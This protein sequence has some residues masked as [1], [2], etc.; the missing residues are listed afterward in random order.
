MTTIARRIV[1][2]QKARFQD[3]LLHL[4]LDLTYVTDHI[5]IM[6]FPA[7][8]VASLYRN[9]RSDVRRFLDKR[10]DDLYRVYNFCP[11]TEN[12]Y[13]PDEFYGRVSRFP[14]PDHHVP[15][16]SLIPLFVADITEYLES[17][18][19][20][21][22][23]IHCKA[24]K[25]RSGTMTCCY[26]VSLPYLPT[27][28]TSVRNYSKMQRPENQSVAPPPPLAAN[29][30]ST[31][32]ERQPGAVQT[33]TSTRML[34]P[35]STPEPPP[36]SSSSSCM[37]TLQIPRSAAWT[38]AAPIV[39]S[40]AGTLRRRPSL[41]PEQSIIRNDDLNPQAEID[42]I[43]QRLQTIFDLHTERRM[44]PPSKKK[45]SATIGRQRSR[46][47]AAA[48][49]RPSAH[50]TG[51]MNSAAVSTASLRA[52]GAGPAGRSCDAL[53][54]VSSQ[55]SSGGDLSA[56]L[57][58]RFATHSSRASASISRDSHNFDDAYADLSG[59]TMDAYALG[60]SGDAANNN[61]SADSIAVNQNTEDHSSTKAP[62]MGVSIPSQRRWVGYWTR[63][64]SGRDARLSMTSPLRQP[65]RLI[66]ITRISVD[67]HAPT[68]TSQSFL[69][70]LVP[71]SDALSV[72]LVRYQDALVDRLESWER[73]A[74]RRARAFGQHDPSAQAGDLD[75]EQQQ[76]KQ[77]LKTLRRKASDLHCW[78]GGKFGEQHEGRIGN[79]GVCVK[80][81]ADR[82]RAFDWRDDQPQLE[83]FALLSET[84][85]RKVVESKVWK[86]T[87]EPKGQQQDGESEKER[88]SSTSSADSGYY[89]SATTANTNAQ[90]VASQSLAPPSSSTP[91][92]D[93]H[94]GNGTLRK[95]TRKASTL[96]TRTD[97]N[98]HPTATRTTSSE[99]D[100]T[101]PSSTS[102][103]P[104]PNACSSSSPGLSV[105]QILDADR[106][107]CVKILV[108]R[109]GSKHAKLPD[110]ASAGWCWFIPSFE[111]PDAG[112]AG[113]ARKG[114]KTQI[115]FEAHE[116]DFRK[117]PLGLKAIEVEWEWVSVGLDDQEED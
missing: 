50:S 74:R 48:G 8:G 62:K 15:P 43:S 42:Q 114:A 108:G 94:R 51:A 29:A 7:S 65:R 115:R 97:A 34:P 56:S 59:S 85:E 39:P 38:Q 57:Y 88:Q 77:Y 116:I 52:L 11:L 92:L 95:M 14:F 45:S 40:Q 31:L 26:L 47:Q 63:I 28:P 49:L 5:I 104:H 73:H 86:Y 41:A 1:S 60:R 66:R 84:A 67:R 76:Q 75:A 101:P 71:H 98:T 91:Q 24:G 61:Q 96:F 102:Y 46:S 54:H 20:A 83:Y 90:P 64:L 4:D 78:D 53:H 44:K 93:S 37:T 81:E 3:P 107:V 2:G 58:S 72:Q 79:W 13:D 99:E 106:E 80:A 117:Q 100:T 22:A 9:K 23:V 6:G 27:A 18:P 25:G 112:V 82:A 21:T 89:S 110:I 109:T 17:D 19:D 69:E 35:G 36:R 16:L 68:S 30:A 32:T 12:S 10:H 103:L 33:P 113:M 55:R 70:R 87:F 105:G 111:D